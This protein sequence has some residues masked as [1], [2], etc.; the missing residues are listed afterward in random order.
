VEVHQPEPAWLY[1]ALS[2]FQYLSRL[3]ENWDTYGGSPLSDDAIYT[4]LSIIA[5]LL[6]DES[7]PPAI[8]PTSE[9]GVQLEWHRAGDELEIRV[10]P[11]GA[12][13]AFRC[14]EV[15]GEMAEIEQV[16]LTDLRPLVELAGPI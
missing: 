1:P 3:D 2:R 16:S 4:A 9:G 15:A 11:S 7:A 12:I 5:R 13:S 14:N 8:V 10:A 6:R